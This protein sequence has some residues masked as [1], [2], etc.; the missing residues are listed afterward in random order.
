MMQEL[1]FECMILIFTHNKILINIYLDI[2]KKIARLL[3]NYST[4][5]K[6]KLKQKIFERTHITSKRNIYGAQK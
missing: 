5:V 3:D 4:W 1:T 6:K 2:Q